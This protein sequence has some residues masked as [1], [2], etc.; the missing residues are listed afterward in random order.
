MVAACSSGGTKL[1][2]AAPTT[3]PPPPHNVVVATHDSWAA[4]KALLAGFESSSGF[5][6]DVQTNGDAGELTNKLV[7]TKDSPIADAVYGI[8]NTF[9]SRAIDAGV[10]AKY[11]S[12]AV[13][14]TQYDI[15][16]GADYL[17]PIDWGDVCV[18]VDDAW[19]AKHQLAAPS[20][21]DD[22]IK[23]LYKNLFVA[24]GA[25]TSS[26]G[27]AFLLATIAQYGDS[28]SSGWQDYWKKLMANGTKL[29]SGWDDAFDVDYTAGGG[30][31]D[32]PIVLSYNSDPVSSI[33][34]GGTKPT[35]HALLNTCFRQVEYASVLAG[36]KNP[37]AAKAFIDFLASRAFQESLPDNMYVFPVDAGAKLPALW[38]KWAPPAPHPLS[39]DPA[40]IAA[41]RSNWLTQWSD[42]TS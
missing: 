13:T 1:D 10:L 5:H 14:T 31:G 26:P 24:P 11:R 7:L 2:G 4:P 41:N 20:S 30:N 18:N 35:T 37:V 19:F 42:I 16:G 27:F 3:S 9:A 8:D 17:T 25:A 28:P 36:A 15:P 32:R 39:V 33:P 38:A 23:P 12:P 40:Q 22:L 21:L 6:L 34:K 29:T